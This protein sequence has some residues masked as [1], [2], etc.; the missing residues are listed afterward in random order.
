MSKERKKIKERINPIFSQLVLPPSLEDAR[1]Q[2]KL[3][4]LDLSIGISNQRQ[5]MNHV[6]LDA[7]GQ[8]A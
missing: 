5:F 8:K 2:D 4:V 7:K 3:E 1:I 6:Q